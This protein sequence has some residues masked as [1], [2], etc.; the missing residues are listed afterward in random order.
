VSTTRIRRHLNAPPERVYRALIDPKAIAEWRVPQGMTSHVHEHDARE[1]GAFRVS[2]T[3]DAP[4]AA[5][6]TSAHTDTYHGRFVKL[7]PAV[8]LVEVMEF[9][10]NEP[11][12]Q[13]EM[14]VRYLLSAA[15]G[16][17]DLLA[18]HEGVPAGVPPADNELGWRMALDKLAALVQR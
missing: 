14:T 18:T 5:G 9:E 15:D 4:N 7:V 6:K 12:L 2:L 13:G 16:G 1:G 17:T 10:T 3:Y 11:S 8:E